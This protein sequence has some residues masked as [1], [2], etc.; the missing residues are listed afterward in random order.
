LSIAGSWP[1]TA[2]HTLLLLLWEPRGAEASTPDFPRRLF[3]EFSGFGFI[4]LIETAFSRFVFLFPFALILSLTTLALRLRSPRP[5]RLRLIRQP[6]FL[7]PL[8]ASAAS[9]P[10][11]IIELIVATGTVE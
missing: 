5:R 10:L 3:S 2:W 8:F 4:G 7:A 1:R 9:V 6:G 11:G